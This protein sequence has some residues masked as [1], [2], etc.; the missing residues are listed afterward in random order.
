VMP[1]SKSEIA[2]AVR[3]G[4]ISPN[5]VDSDMESANVVDVLQYLANAAAKIAYAITR[6]CDIQESMITELRVEDDKPTSLTLAE[7]IDRIAGAI[8][9]QVETQDGLHRIAEALQGEDPR[10]PTTVAE[11][12]KNVATQ[13][14]WLGTG[15]AATKMGA[16]EFLATCVRDGCERVGSSIDNLAD[17]VRE[18]G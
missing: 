12:L 13:L 17:A 10:Q 11:A 16:I 18:R 5:G 7:S 6:K 15:N 2:A 1:V 4:L 8:H 9:R 14:K 3:D